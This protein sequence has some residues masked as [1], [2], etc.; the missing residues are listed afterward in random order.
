MNLLLV[1]RDYSGLTMFV[2]ALFFP[3]MIVIMSVIWP[4]RYMVGGI[5]GFVTTMLFFT[6]GIISLLFF[7]G[8]KISERN[9]R[10]VYS[11]LPI[12]DRD[13]FRSK[14]LIT[15]LGSL[16]SL[17]ISF[18][19]LD[20]MGSPITLLTSIKIILLYIIVS[21]ELLLLHTILFGKFNN[22]YTLTVENSENELIKLGILFTL[23]F[24]TIISYLELTTLL[25]QVTSV[26]V[27][28]G[29]SIILAFTFFLGLNIITNFFTG[30]NII[31]IRHS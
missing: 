21:T 22:R 15:T 6:S 16:F 26:T 28:L 18:I 27:E 4:K 8:S 23:I 1:F 30:D 9:L 20:F 25:S 7:T 29:I 10:G 19:I 31:T 14:Q 5:R 13:I 2:M 12:K 24:I 3:I 17:S 11:S